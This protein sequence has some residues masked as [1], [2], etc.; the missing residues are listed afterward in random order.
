MKIH[1]NDF[2]GE[3]GNLLDGEVNAE[4]RAHLEAHLA[5]CKA[6]SVVFDTTKRTI[7][8]VTES[9]SFDLSVDEWKATTDSVMETIRK[10]GAPQ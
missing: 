7:T 10:K 4:L 1:C 9:E 8:I 6:C 3:I 2:V 5:E